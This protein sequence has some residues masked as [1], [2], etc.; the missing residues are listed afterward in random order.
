VIFLKGV[1]PTKDVEEEAMDEEMMGNRSIDFKI[2]RGHQDGHLDSFPLKEP[3]A[4]VS[5]RTN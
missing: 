1:I 5:G 3:G 4:P 2:M